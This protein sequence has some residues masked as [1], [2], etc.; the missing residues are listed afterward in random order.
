MKSRFAPMFPLALVAFLAACSPKAPAP[1]PVRA[2]RTMTVTADSAGLTHEYAAEVRARVESRLGFRVGGKMT[3]RQANVGQR[4]KAGQVLAQLDPT[5]LRLGQ[6]SAQ[7]GVRAAQVNQEQAAAEVRRYKDLRDQG[8]ISAIELERRNS[9]LQAANAQLEQARAQAGVQV[10]QAGYAALVAPAAGVVTAVEAE[11]GAV[12]AAGASVLRLAHDGPRDA[13][14]FVPEDTADAF[15][16]LQGRPGALTVRGWAAKTSLPATVREVAAAADPATRTFLVKADLGAAPVQLGQTL[17]AVVQAPVQ[18]G[19]NKLP[20]S[21]VLQ[22]QGTTA[23]WLVDRISMTVKLQPVAVGGADGNS[24]VI[25]GG[26]Q[27]GQTVVT[28]GVHLLSPGQKVSF[29]EPSPPPSP[30]P[31]VAAPAASR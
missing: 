10:N 14:F 20:L 2:V 4:V 16:A 23:V 13:V 9:T 24:V 21:A 15:R 28:A 18:A 8:F 12:L 22:Q 1:E 31:A 3:V 26:L 7:A 30:P 11:A 19:V 5:D 29:Y 17:T 27:T 6:E 25:V